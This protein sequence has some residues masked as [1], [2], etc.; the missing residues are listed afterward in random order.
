MGQSTL[1]P[2]EQPTVLEFETLAKIT[3]FWSTHNTVDFEHLPHEV[4]FALALL[5]E[6]HY[7]TCPKLAKKLQQ[8]EQALC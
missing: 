6:S 2:P 3:K 8:M 5:T 1:I 7:Q 4:F